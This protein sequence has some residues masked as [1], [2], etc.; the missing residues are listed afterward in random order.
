MIHYL[1]HKIQNEIIQLLGDRIK[2]TIIS[3]LKQSKYFSIILDCTPDI[4]HEEQISV[5]VRFVFLNTSTNKVEVKEHFLGF[6][7]I[8]DTTGEELTTFLLNFIST[9]NIDLQDMR[10]QGYDNGSNMKGNKIGLQ[11]SI[12]EMNPRAFYVPCAA[13][14]LNL[15]VNDAAKSSLEITNF[16]SIV[17]EIYVFFS[18]S[19]AR[20]QILIS[21]VPTLTLKPLSTTRWESRVEALKALRFN[22]G[23]VYDVLY[24]I[25]LILAK[26]PTQET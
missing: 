12:L 7:P 13:H 26:I 3:N 20:W 1:G 5:V 16:F 6:F 10:G 18:A 14:S 22:L 8:K 11:K 9:S 15:V 23:K 2:K 25:Y 21:E 4:S 17:Q 24:S 19:T